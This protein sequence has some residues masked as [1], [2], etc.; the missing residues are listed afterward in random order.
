[1][2]NNE[3]GALGSNQPL[4]RVVPEK[5]EKPRQAEK[6]AVQNNDEKLEVLSDERCRIDNAHPKETDVVYLREDLRRR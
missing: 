4:E 5:T 6:P 1:M 2:S 3:H